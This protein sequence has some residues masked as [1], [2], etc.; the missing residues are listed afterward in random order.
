MADAPKPAGPADAKKEAPKEVK[1]DDH[2]H[3]SIFKPFVDALK[4]IIT[5]GGTLILSFFLVFLNRE[6]A[7]NF[8][9]FLN[10]LEIFFVL[11]AIFLIYK[12]FNFKH[13][14]DH[15]VHDIHH[16]FSK[17]YVPSKE[18]ELAKI[19]HNVFK[20]EKSKAH[21]ASRFPEEWKIGI[22]ELDTVLKNLL[23][24][25]NYTGAGIVEMLSDAYEKGFTKVREALEAHK[26][27]TRIV[28][29]GV[30]YDLTQAEAEAALSNYEEVFKELGIK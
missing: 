26:L 11:Y 16:R 14:F 9:Y 30:K 4:A 12:F 8:I 19:S 29:V 28:R 22:I 17:M 3:P 20:F 13:K 27:R 24:E 15:H 21:I 5:V 25:N 1:K 18:D 10:A 7:I 23:I 6:T 2:G